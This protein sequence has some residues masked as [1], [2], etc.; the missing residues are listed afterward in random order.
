MPKCLNCKPWQVSCLRREAQPDCSQAGCSLP[1]HSTGNNGGLPFPG[2]GHNFTQ[3]HGGADQVI[4]RHLTKSLFKIGLEC[5]TKLYY[6]GNKAYAN[7][8]IEDSFLLALAEGGFQVGEL[9]KH[10]Y[11]GGHMIGSL[12]YADALS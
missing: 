10:Y 9:A 5:P 2:F 7:Q 8:K 6:E 3:K 4:N 11:A 12:D 1:K